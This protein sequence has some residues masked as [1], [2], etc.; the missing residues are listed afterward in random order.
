[1]T[2]PRYNGGMTTHPEH[3]CGVTLIS[4]ASSG[5]GEALAYELASK[6]GWVALAARRLESLQAVA[7]K[8]EALG[9]RALP[10]ACD[11]AERADCQAAV[12]QTVAHFGRLDTLINNAGITMWARADSLPDGALIEQIMRVNF[13]G[14]VELTAAA[15]PHLKQTHGRITCIS[16]MASQIIA[17]GNSGYA[18]SK[19]AMDSY[20][21][22]LRAELIDS[23]VSVTLYNLG[24]VETGIASRMHDAQ[25]QQAGSIADLI[26]RGAQITPDAAA[27]QIITAT[28]ARR[29][30]VFSS[31]GGL[32][33]RLIAVLRLLLPGVVERAGIDFM[34]RGGL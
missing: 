16:S 20:F 31:V 30:R 6:G 28:V 4:G 12:A 19:A 24:F 15:L 25:G 32:P 18:A 2:G 3:P 14:A 22:A 23:G 27:R 34:K 1:M 13:L 9:G 21:E 5:I 10:L 26:P 7:A 29:R 8:C 17:P 11:V 33:G